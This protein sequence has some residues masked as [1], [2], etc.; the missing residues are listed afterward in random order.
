M[1]K[2][3]RIL[4]LSD[5]HGDRAAVSRLEDYLVGKKFDYV[6]M[7]G[8]Y[9]GHDGFHD[10]NV[11][12]EDLELLLGVLKNYKVKAIPGNCDRPE[13]LEVLDKHDINLHEK[14][15]KMSGVA[16]IGLGG[17]NK[18]PFNTPFE[19]TEEEI[20][21]KLKKL[22]EASKSEHIVMVTHCPPKNTKCDVVGSGAHVGSSAL[23]QIVD[24]YKPSA[25][26]CSHIH[27]SGGLEDKVE[28]TLV[29]NVGKL[30]DGKIAVIDISDTV[31]V[32]ADRIL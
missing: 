16:F 13:L 24:A 31:D 8:D 11:N 6:F 1:T 4:C 27:E 12:R 23:R 22:I 7:L 21:S 32:R 10:I 19:L 15:I 28:D 25:I 17:S 29:V 2:K 14:T 30:S 26:V 5:V 9:S 3:M 20:H 18:T